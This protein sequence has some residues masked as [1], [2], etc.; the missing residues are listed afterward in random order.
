MILQPK[1][2]A[3]RGFASAQLGDP[4]RARRAVTRAAARFD[5][6][7]AALPQQS[8]ALKDLRAAGRRQGADFLVRACQDRRI[9]RPDGAADHLLSWARALPAQG[10]QSLELPARSARAGQP[11][12]AAQ[13]RIAFAAATVRPP[14]HGGH[15]RPPLPA[16]VVRVWEPEPP[17]GVEPLEWVLVT[18]VPVTAADQAWE[19]VA[20]YR[21]RWLCADHH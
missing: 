21:C 13:L 14:A 15:G 1:A 8:G 6:A 18:S 4:R 17:P 5:N 7:A 11:D 3:E 12:P 2:L 20:W 16:W 19:R 9:A 10:E